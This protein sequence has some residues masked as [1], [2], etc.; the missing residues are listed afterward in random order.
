VK[1]VCFNLVT[2]NPRPYSQVVEA[3]DYLFISGTTGAVNPETGSKVTGIQAQTRQCLDNINKLL[4]K[5]GSSLDEVVKCTVFIKNQE[6]FAPMNEVYRTYFIKDLPAR[7]TIVT[8]L[9]APEMVIEIECIAYHP[10]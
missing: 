9:V 8:G 2:P 7:S 6:D 3:G 4:T 5:A 1:K 10:E